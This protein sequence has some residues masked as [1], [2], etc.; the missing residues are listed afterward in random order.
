MTPEQQVALTVGIIAAVAALLVGILTA[1]AALFGAAI[2]L[3]GT[4]VVWKLQRRAEKA[5]RSESF[6]RE[7]LLR[8]LDL[9]QEYFI[10]TSKWLVAGRPGDFVAE[11]FYRVRI[12]IDDCRARS[13]DEKLRSLLAAF[14]LIRVDKATTDYETLG[15]AYIGPCKPVR[16]RVDELLH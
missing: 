1:L 7:N 10:V 8:L 6:Q 4:L 14:V 5:D 2:G 12:S 11:P 13:T 15:L 16:D 9:L 3:F